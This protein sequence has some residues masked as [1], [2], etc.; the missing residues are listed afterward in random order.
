MSPI[1]VESVGILLCLQEV[2]S[3]LKDKFKITVDEFMF[4]PYAKSAEVS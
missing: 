3:R 1:N 4:N 2:G